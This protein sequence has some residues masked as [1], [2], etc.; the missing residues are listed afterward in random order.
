MSGYESIA[1]QDCGEETIRARPICSMCESFAAL[2]SSPP[3]AQPDISDPQFKLWWQTPDA[4]TGKTP[5]SFLELNSALAAWQAA[6]APQ[7]L[8]WTKMH[9]RL[10]ANLAEDPSLNATTTGLQAP[11]ATSA[12][13]AAPARNT[14]TVPGGVFEAVGSV[15]LDHVNGDYNA[16]LDDM[17]VTA[18]DQLYRFIPAVACAVCKSRGFAPS[19]S[20]TGCEFCDG[21][22][23]GASPGSMPEAQHGDGLDADDITKLVRALS[24]LGEST[25]ES[26]EVCGI[27]RYELVRRLIDANLATR[28][29][30]MA[31]AA[32][33]SAEASP[34]KDHEIRLA[35]NQL[36]EV[37]IRFHRA[38]QLR[39]R[40][41]DIVLPLLARAMTKS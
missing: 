18:G 9:E 23:C 17:R 14:V 8:V 32:Q 3:P 24:W 25:P 27:R 30:A 37:S 40:I 6:R 35:V 21:T 29:Y 12:P 31:Q 22:E 13:E 33:S 16:A 38:G 11:E 36:C 5:S 34:V 28:D 7:G 20:G 4:K 10:L 26:H 1:C 41:Q 19:R 39:S 15:W 2:C